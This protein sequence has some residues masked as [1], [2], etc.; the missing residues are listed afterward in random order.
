MRSNWLLLLALTVYTLSNGSP[1]AFGSSSG[2]EG[3]LSGSSSSDDGSSSDDDYLEQLGHRDSDSEDDTTDD[4]FEDMDVEPED[5]ADLDFEWETQLVPP[6]GA[7]A[8]VKELA[9]EQQR[10]YRAQ[11]EITD[12]L[13]SN[14]ACANQAVSELI[15]LWKGGYTLE[16]L[17][18]YLIRH[19]KVVLGSIKDL[20]SPH[21]QLLKGTLGSIN[22]LQPTSGHLHPDQFVNILDFAFEVAMSTS[23]E[24]LGKIRTW[25]ELQEFL[26]LDLYEL[27]E[28]VPTSESMI[29][30]LRQL[31]FGEEIIRQDPTGCLKA[32]LAEIL[33]LVHQ[34]LRN[35]GSLASHAV[36]DAY[37]HPSTVARGVTWLWFAVEGIGLVDAT[38]RGDFSLFLPRTIAMGSWWMYTSYRPFRRPDAT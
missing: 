30:K 32:A 7:D 20:K 13:V 27:I 21:V 31:G 23:H 34:T 28:E 35:T 25:D 16:K 10:F 15:R 14:P 17:K 9:S 3:Y 33:E 38:M 2:D 29:D 36:H 11:L 22:K 19:L 18:P 24:R 6:P 1:R 12:R 37:E 4:D 26:S 5:L 8:K